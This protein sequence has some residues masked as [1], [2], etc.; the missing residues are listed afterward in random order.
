M[1]TVRK[2]VLRDNKLSKLL[3]AYRWHTNGIRELHQQQHITNVTA[4]IREK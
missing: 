2:E 3:K 4:K 1:Y